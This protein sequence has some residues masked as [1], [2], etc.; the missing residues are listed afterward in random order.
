[1]AETVGSSFVEIL[2][3]VNIHEH[4]Y[5]YTNF[6]DFTK[7]G[8]VEQEQELPLQNGF[9]GASI[10]ENHKRAPKNRGWVP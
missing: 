6:S 1:M 5:T 7:S 3:F 8:N 9:V 10:S 4:K 2:G